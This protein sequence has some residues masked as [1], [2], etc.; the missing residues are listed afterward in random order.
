MTLVAEVA[1]VR[2]QVAAANLDMSSAPRNVRHERRPTHRRS[3]EIA[4][5]HQRLPPSEPAPSL[6]VGQGRRP[7]GRVSWIGFWLEAALLRRRDMRRVRSGKN[8]R[9]LNGYGAFADTRSAPLRACIGAI[10]FNYVKTSSLALAG[11]KPNRLP[12][13]D[14]AVARPRLWRTSA[15]VEQA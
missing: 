14:P 2:R 15:F 3:V 6:V 10:W 4:R 5:D 9:E 11:H 8:R 7:R 13:F 12:R 1:A